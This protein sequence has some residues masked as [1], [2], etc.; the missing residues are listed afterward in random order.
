MRPRLREAVEVV[1]Y[2][3]NESDERGDGSPNL[4]RTSDRIIVTLLVWATIE[5]IRVHAH[6]F[7]ADVDLSVTDEDDLLALLP[8][9]GAEPDLD[10]EIPIHTSH[11]AAVAKAALALVNL[12]D[13]QSY[14]PEI[15]QSIENIA[16]LTRT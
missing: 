8:A 6:A 16:R 2:W 1:R 5:Y 11:L 14:R 3:L 15:L 4:V 10:L 7:A 9:H 13:Q 12:R